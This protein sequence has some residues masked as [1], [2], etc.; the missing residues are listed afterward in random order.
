[1][2]IIF[3]TKSAER[4]R[5]FPVQSK[6]VRESC[7]CIVPDLNDDIG[8][9][10][11]SEAQLLLKSKEVGPHGTEIEGCAEIC[12]FYIGEDGSSVQCVSMKKEFSVGF[13]A[14]DGEGETEAQALLSCRGI[15]ARTLNP[16]KLAVDI[17]IG[18]DLF[19]FVRDE[20]NVE[21]APPEDAPGGLET[22]RERCTALVVSSVA[23]KSFTV[24]EQLPVPEEAGSGSRVV[25]ASASL[26]TE[27]VQMLGSKALLKGSARIRLAF[28]GEG[29]TCPVFSE[30]AL[31]F[32]LL[33]DADA[34]DREPAGIRLQTT[35]L[36]AD[37]I[38]AINGG[39]LAE[40]ELHGTAQIAF[41]RHEEIG[42]VA[43]AYGTRCP[44]LCCRERLEVC[45]GS[46]NRELYAS[47]EERA[48]LREP[49]AELIAR[50]ASFACAEPSDGKARASAVIG[51]VLRYPDGSLGAVQK[52]LQFEVEPPS[53]SCAADGARLD[54][55]DM[56]ISGEEL[57][58]TAEA[59]F[60]FIEKSVS[61]M[62]TICG[63]ELN[64]ESPYDPLST[65]DLTVTR[66]GGRDMWTL[67]KTYRTSV[68]E[69]EELSKA[70]PPVGDTILV[71]GAGR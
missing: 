48:E 42:Y 20:L 6:V 24:S 40:V 37:T 47:A 46:E 7:E 71:P 65:P 57:V 60:G 30:H 23:E 17:A 41:S 28:C 39:Y 33:A 49:E 4:F 19:Y 68:R 12:V 45:G 43:D 38:E 59:C 8:K 32:S 36:Y 63:V 14:P 54:S 44:A 62:D 10:A 26:Y 67:A 34:E 66:I 15:Q 61:G 58:I 11:F 55:C 29:M 70:F 56:R 22:K 1:M 25:F 64:E 51:A 50:S 3:N 53:E 35:A 52:T 16:R 31:P 9:I 5:E 27:D 69:I 18:A 13:D 2:E 21:C